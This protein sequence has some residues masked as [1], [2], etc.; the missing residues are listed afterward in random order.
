[1]GVSAPARRA[2]RPR[3][4]DRG[5]DSGEILNTAGIDPAPSRDRGP[6]W[7]D[8]L[9]SQAQAILAADFVVVDLLDGTKI[10]VLAVIEHASRRIRIL[11]ATTNP[12]AEWMVQQARNLLM[13]LEEATTQVRFLIHDRDASFCAALDQLLADAGIQMLRTGVKAPRQ[14]AIMQ[15]WFRCMR[16]ALTDRGLIWNVA[17][18]RRLL[19]E[20]ET[21]YNTHRPHRALGQAAPLRPL[22]NNVIDLDTFRV[23]RLDRAGGLLHEYQH[24]A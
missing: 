7:A 4:H 11:G 13:D 8:F 15:R 23:Q 17:H 9:G 16:A 3:H 20:Y 10:Y 12:I 6:S 5:V 18:L 19:R 2:C 22:P 21:F 14:N 1:M 24:V